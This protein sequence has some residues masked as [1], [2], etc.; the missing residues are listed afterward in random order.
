MTGFAWKILEISAD[1]DLITHAKYLVTA[2]DEDGTQVMTEGNWWFQG[3]EIVKPFSEVTEDD[4]ARWIE[5]ETTQFGENS[6]KSRLEEQLAYLKKS[7]V[8]VPPWLP[9][10]Y[11]P[12]L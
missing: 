8:V 10:I 1:G 12:N 4:V 6:I 11:T 5:E 2:E 7:R 9:Q 3:K